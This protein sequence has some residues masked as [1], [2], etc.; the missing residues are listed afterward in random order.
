MHT[1]DND[2]FV[3]TKDEPVTIPVTLTFDKVPNEVTFGWLAVRRVPEIPLAAVHTPLN[4]ALI[5]SNVDDVVTPDTCK[6]LK[7]PK[8]VM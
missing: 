6:S 8:D 4:D 1:P 7:V 5:P 3:P 2:K